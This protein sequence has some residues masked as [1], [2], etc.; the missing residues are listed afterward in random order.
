MT[1]ILRIGIRE[2]NKERE[3]TG[4]L[5]AMKT[6]KLKEGLIL[7]YEQTE[8]FERDG[9]KIRIIPVCNWMLEL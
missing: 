6:F 9:K 5:D 1:I 2:S 7:T 8:E 4:L 3:I